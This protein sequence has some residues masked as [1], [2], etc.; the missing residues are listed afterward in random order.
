MTSA[1]AWKKVVKQLAITHAKY[2]GAKDLPEYDMLRS[3][4]WMS[5]QNQNRWETAVDVG[6]RAWGHLDKTEFSKRL[7]TFIDKA[8]SSADFQKASNEMN[9]RPKT[10]VMGD[11]H[12]K[13][14]FWNKEKD[15]IVCTDFSEIGVG[16]PLSDIV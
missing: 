13:N 12:A 2:W 15:E 8:Y 3:A 7:V 1:E 11:C 10:L 5:G 9:N 16:D 4:D 6:R 14:I